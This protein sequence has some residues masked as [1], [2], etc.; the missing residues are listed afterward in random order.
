MRDDSDLKISLRNL[1]MEDYLNLKDSMAQAYSS[2]GGSTWSEA[3]IQRL[4]QKFPD[5]QIGILVN[6]KVV[7][8]ALSLI[9]DFKK[10]SVNHSYGEITANY[11]IDSHD[12]KGDVLY[13]IELFIH[14]DYRGLRLARRLYDARKELCENLNLKSII[15][16]G[17]I[18]GYQTYSKQLTPKQYIEKVK[19]KEIYDPVLSFQLAN[20][21]HIKRV[22]KGYLSGDNVSLEYA[23]LIE[24]L[25]IYYEPR[26]SLINQRKSIVRLGLVQW[27][28]RSHKDLESLTDQIEFFVDAVSDYNSD[29]ILFPELFNAPLMAEFNNLGEA[30][31]IRG[32]AGYTQ[33]I[34][35][36]F[37]EF[38]VSYNINIITGS[39]PLLENK[40]LYN[41]S[42]L[43]R[44]DGSY[45]E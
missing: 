18:P 10:Y 31:A 25:N 22:I 16:G 45:E 7:G 26:Q 4:L 9:V 11:S 32:L 42:Y 21:F 34:L 5:G 20:D 19:A 2:M 24:W 30:Q 40:P 39:M 29:F 44:R 8:C 1:Q 3:S 6:D 14:P 27:Q 28:M 12:Y 33:A 23:T 43:C 35:T 15:A 36:K 17:R 38:A 37:K 41:V 13:G